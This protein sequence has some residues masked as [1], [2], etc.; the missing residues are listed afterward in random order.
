MGN[1]VCR[2]S[3]EHT[4][5]QL[6]AHSIVSKQKLSELSDILNDLAV[7]IEQEQ[8]NDI[9]Q[10]EHFFLSE[11]SWY[12]GDDLSARHSV[13]DENRDIASELSAKESDDPIFEGALKEGKN[14]VLRWGVL[15]SKELK[16]YS[17]RFSAIFGDSPI[18]RLPRIQ[19]FC[20]NSYV[21]DDLF[22][23][24]IRTEEE[25]LQ[26]PKMVCAMTPRSV[27]VKSNFRILS[28][29]RTARKS[30]GIPDEFLIDKRLTIGFTRNEAFSEWKEA[31]E[32][33]G[34]FL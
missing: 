28:N 7:E 34:L 14:S 22:F 21:R 10:D 19:M 3:C 29:K 24:E 11:D 30:T 17:S 18:V 23:I 4:Q 2:E 27:D 5:T 32:Q 6:V 1:S 25:Q 16:I 31:L 26:L 12:Q 20:G 8:I 33:V 15:T 13:P 9:A